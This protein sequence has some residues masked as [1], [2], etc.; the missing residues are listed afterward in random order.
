MEFDPSFAENFPKNPCVKPEI[1]TMV[2]MKPSLTI[3]PSPSHSTTFLYKNNCNQFK[4]HR[5]NGANH[6]SSFAK[7]VPSYINPFSMIPTPSFNAVDDI[8]SRREIFNGQNPMTFAPNN[9]KMEVMHGRLNT[10]KGILDSSKNIL[11]QYG[12]TSESRFKSKLQGDFSGIGGTGNN[13]RDGDREFVLSEQKRQKRNQN[14]SE[15]QPRS[16]LNIIK[17]Q[18]TANEDRNLVQ[19]VDHFGLRRWSKIAKHL[20]GRIGKQC[21]ERWNNHLRPDIKKESWSEEEDKVL[22]EVHKIVGNKWAEIA[23][24]LPG[25]TENSIKNHWNATKRSLNA[26][27]RPNRRNSL[28][29]T[30]LQKY[31]CQVTAVEEAE[32]DLMMKNPMN[33]MNIENQQNFESS[34][35]D[36]ISEGLATPEDEIEHYVPMMF[37]G[38]ADYGMASGSGSGSG[39]AMNYDF[40]SYGMA[41]GSGTAMNYEFYPEVPMKQELDLMEMIYRNNP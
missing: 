17:G 9:N 18:W 19:L 37:N 5:L 3:S 24:S 31:I 7:M 22:I 14:N 39:T 34:E 10:G 27:K 40:G 36:Y 23:K 2:S 38:T 11:F 8:G 26:K 29:G 1:P 6:H 25:R 4:E 28:K 15:I 41:S 16:D 30:L 13:S 12:V 21:R 33:M 32:K 35:S 20:K